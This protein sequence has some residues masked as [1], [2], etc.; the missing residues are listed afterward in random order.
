MTDSSVQLTEEEIKKY[1]ITVVPLS[2]TIDGKTY[3]DGVDITRRDFIERMDED[4]D[5]P[6]TSQPPIGRFV[7]TIKKLTADGSEVLGI[8]LAKSLSGTIDAAKQAASI[9]PDAKVVCHDSGYTDRSEGYEVIAAAQDAQAGKSIDEI[10]DHLKKMEDNMYLE[11]MIPDLTNIVKGGRLGK[12][13]SRVVSMLNIRIFLQ[14]KNGKVL[15]PKKGRG[16][17]FTEKFN[18]ML[19]EQ[20]KELGD[21]VKQVGIS[22]VDTLDAMEK[23]A[24]RFKE[25]NPNVDILIRK[26]SPIIITHAGHGAYAVMFYTE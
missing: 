19:V 25:V 4:S 2:V 17:K 3:V 23:L 10:L 16:K 9:V 22:Y 14:M 20:L 18:D 7:E 1:D 24:A 12:L 11:M 6:K 15:V 8:F 21:Q 13:A 26:T 5:V